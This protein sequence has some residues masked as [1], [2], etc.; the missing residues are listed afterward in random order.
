MLRLSHHKRCRLYRLPP[1][2]GQLRV[3]FRGMRADKKEFGKLTADQFKQ[4]IGTLPELRRQQGE[5]RDAIREV[6]S[7]RLDEL[8][9]D[10]Y[11]WGCVYELTFHEHVALVVHCLGLSPYLKALASVPDPQQKFLD[12]IWDESKVDEAA[13]TA[14]AQAV[15]GLVFSLQRTILSVMLYQRSMSSL[16]QEVREQG[17]SEALFKAVRVDRAVV[18]APSVADRIARAELRKDEVFFRHLRSALK[19]PSRKHWD[20]YND[21]RYA[22]FALRELGFDKLTD[23]QLERLMVDVLRVYPANPSARKNLRAQYQQSRK[24]KTI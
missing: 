17:S 1:D 23:A 13:I 14:P 24:I 8:L 3:W 9:V 10:G 2:A 4:L 5:L 21:L 15:I 18:A 19:G 20:A 11:N 12:E 7:S 16:L 6:P 22:L